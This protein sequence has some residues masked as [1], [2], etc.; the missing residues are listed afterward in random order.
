M[1]LEN[2]FFHYF[3]FPFLIGIVF[4]LIIVIISSIIFTNDYIDKITGNNVAKLGKEYSNININA[5]QD[6][7]SSALL[8]MQAGF[9]ELILLYL[10]LANKL[11]SNEPNNLNRIIDDNYLIC[12]L[13][14]NESHNVNNIQT[15]YM[16]Y[17][18]IDLETNLAKLKPNSFEKV[19]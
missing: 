4:C 11:K 8:K 6:E 7:I 2:Q 12:S 16:A 13:D 17:W 10:N 9:N 3:F 19:N 5:V 14:L 1:K 15:N 18:L